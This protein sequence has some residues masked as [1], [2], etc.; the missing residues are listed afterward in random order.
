MSLH[1]SPPCFQIAD[2]IYRYEDPDRSGITVTS[3]LSLFWL[4]RKLTEDR[5]SLDERS[6][7][8]MTASERAQV[9]WLIEFT[10]SAIFQHS[11]ANG[12]MS[13]KK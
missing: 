3:Y 4:T 6:H 9:G 12:A 10:G 2:D 1:F 5:Y 7:I 11:D 13:G 8:L